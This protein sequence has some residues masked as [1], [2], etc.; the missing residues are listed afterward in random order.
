[1][2]SQALIVL[3]GFVGKKIDDMLEKQDITTRIFWAD[4]ETRINAKIVDIKDLR[5]YI[6]P[7]LLEY[8]DASLN[9]L[10]VYSV[11]KKED[12]DR[13]RDACRAYKYIN[14]AKCRAGIGYKTDYMSFDKLVY[15][16]DQRSFIIIQNNKI[17]G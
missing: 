5:F 9:N 17:K 7:F 2:E 16:K 3:A 11:Y 8:V 4:G 12:Y 14:P 15:S 1:M 6:K 10:N 13:I